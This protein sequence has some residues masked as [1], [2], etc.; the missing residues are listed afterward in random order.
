MEGH[1]FVSEVLD[2]LFGFSRDIR[3]GEDSRNTCNLF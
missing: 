3:D 2:E 1:I